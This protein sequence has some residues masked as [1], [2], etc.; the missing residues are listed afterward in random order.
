VDKNKIQSICNVFPQDVVCQILL[1]LVMSYK[2]IQKKGGTFLKH[3]IHRCLA[4][5]IFFI[6]YLSIVTVQYA[7]LVL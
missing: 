7:F 2:V 3:N 5:V 6:K 1:K 4:K